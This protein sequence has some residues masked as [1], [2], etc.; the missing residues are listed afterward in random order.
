[1]PV[2]WESHGS[3]GTRT[4][5]LKR[6]FDSCVP[7]LHDAVK[8]VALSDSQSDRLIRSIG[9]RLR[10]RRLLRSGV[11][12]LSG[13]LVTRLDEAG[14]VSE[15]DR[16]H[17]VAEV[18]LAEHVVEVCLDGGFAHDEFCGDFGVGEAAGDER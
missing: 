4:R 2:C 5:D 14:L 11:S 3:D 12:G 17:A 18:E 6:R 16:L 8:Q 15:Y 1:M 13:S 9:A 7:H 10:V